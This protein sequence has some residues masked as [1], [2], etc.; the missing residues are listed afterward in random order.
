MNADQGPYVELY[1]R[2]QNYDGDSLF[3]DL[4]Q[5]WLDAN[6][7]ERRWLREFAARRGNPV[8]PATVD[9]TIRLYALSR[10]VDVLQLSFQPR[11]PDTGWDSASVSRDEF[12]R[13]MAGLG[14]E[15]IGQPRF[16]PFFHEIVTVDDLPDENASPEIVD[17]CWPGYMLGP[18]LVSRAG[19]RVRAG[20]RHLV[21]EIAESSMLYWAYARNHRPS[22][23]LSR[24]WG[25]NSQWRTAFRRDYALDGALHYNVDAAAPPFAM[26]EDLDQSE[27]TE[28]L[29]HRCFVTCPQPD[30]DRWPY[31]LTLVENA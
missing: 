29:R 9:E 23:D 7:A 5:P 2:M 8:P 22:T 26:D 17:V 3:A 18:L 27:R 4:L 11:T 20:R 16:H 15:R 10:I 14:L 28:L 21:K 12:D 19:V 30:D 31:G 13:F 1:D 25:S 24:G 6:D